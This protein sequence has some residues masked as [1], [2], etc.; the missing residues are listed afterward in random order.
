[1]NPNWAKASRDASYRLDACRAYPKAYLTQIV[2]WW[3]ALRF[4]VKRHCFFLHQRIVSYVHG[5]TY[6]CLVLSNL[7]VSLLLKLLTTPRAFGIDFCLILVPICSWLPVVIPCLNV[8][9]IVS[10]H[11]AAKLIERPVHLNDIPWTIA[12][13][14]SMKALGEERA[15]ECVFL[16]IPANVKK[17]L[18]VDIEIRHVAGTKF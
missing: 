1:M 10:E 6:F 9:K 2:S 5:V 11:K 13:S 8:P 16:K 17:L 12:S 14:C 3:F 7:E 18:C 15:S 4:A